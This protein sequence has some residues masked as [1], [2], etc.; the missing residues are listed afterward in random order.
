MREGLIIVGRDE[1]IDRGNF[2]RNVLGGSEKDF[3]QRFSAARDCNISLRGISPRIDGCSIKK[4]K[5]VFCLLHFAP[6]AGA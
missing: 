1:V 3:D 5:L 4:R 2:R 6:A